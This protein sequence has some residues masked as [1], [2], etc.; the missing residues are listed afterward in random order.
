MT[1]KTLVLILGGARSGKS[2]YAERLAAEW[3]GEEGHMLYVAT[4][5]ALD[6]EMA[7]RIARHRA[8]RP[9]SWRTLEEPYDLG[10]V[11]AAASVAA[12]V[13]LVDCVTLWL[14]N[15]LLGPERDETRAL[16]ADAAEEAARYAVDR[17]LAAHRAGTARTILVSNEV[18]M[19]LVPPNPIGRR[20]RDLL[21][22]VNM[23]LAAAADEVL[24][25]VAGLPLR[26][27]PTGDGPSPLQPA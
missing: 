25:M 18:G 23:W 5:E 15:L 12:S 20:Y 7:Q 19:G 10:P 8:A 26:I 9:A 3:A 17:L 14:S 16:D 24:L 11:I 21:G 27:K 13:V 1:T 4:A 6:E 2:A 22:R